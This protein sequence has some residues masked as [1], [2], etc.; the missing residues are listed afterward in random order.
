MPP[1]R[2]LP[3]FDYDDFDDEAEELHPEDTKPILVLCQTNHAL[4]SVLVDLIGSCP[5]DYESPGRPVHEDRVLRLGGSS[6]VESIK[7]RNAMRVLNQLSTERDLRAAKHRRRSLRNDVDRDTKQFDRNLLMQA[8]QGEIPNSFSEFISRRREEYHAIIRQLHGDIDKITDEIPNHPKISERH[9]ELQCSLHEH[10]QQLAE[11]QSA[12]QNPLDAWLEGV[13]LKGQAPQHEADAADEDVN[14]ARV[15]ADADDELPSLPSDDYGKL[16]PDE[17]WRHFDYWTRHARRNAKQSLYD[18]CNLYED[19][20]KVATRLENEAMSRLMR[21]ARVI[22]ATT[23]GC[24]KFSQVMEHLQ[25]EIIVVE[26]AAEVLESHIL[27]VLSP[28]T[29]HILLIGDHKQ[30]QPKVNVLEMERKGLC[31]SLMERLVLSGMKPSVLLTQRRMREEICAVTSPFYAPLQIESHASTRN[32]PQFIKGLQHPLWFVTHNCPESRDDGS[33][34]H[35]EYEA[36]YAIGL[37]GHLLR[38][39]YEAS[40][41]TILVAYKG[42]FHYL[43]E[44]IRNL[45][46]VWNNAD[47]RGAI[48]QG[49]RRIKVVCVDNFQGEENDI[50][51]LSLVRS[52][53]TTHGFLKRENRLIVALS[54]ARWG[55]YVLANMDHLKT[56][57]AEW[58]RVYSDAQ[59]RRIM[60]PELKIQCRRHNLTAPIK[61]YKDFVTVSEYGGCSRIC[62]VRMDC[63]HPCKRKCH[64]DNYDH[65]DRVCEE[66]CGRVREACIPP[67]YCEHPCMKRCEDDCGE[68]SVMVMKQLSCGHQQKAPCGRSC[69]QISCSQPCKKVLPCGHT[70]RNKC[71]SRCTAC[72]VPVPK[73]LPCGHTVDVPCHMPA[74]E[75]VCPKPCPEKLACDHV[76]GLTCGK[77]TKTDDGIPLHECWMECKRVLVCGHVCSSMCSKMCPPCRKPCMM[78]CDHSKCTKSCG[79]ECVRCAMPCTWSCEHHRC[80]KQCW[81]VCSRKKCDKPCPK[82]LKCGHPCRG[83]CGDPCPEFCAECGIGGELYSNIMLVEP[84]DNAQYIQL[85][86]EHIFDIPTFDHYVTAE[87]GKEK[88]QWLLCPTC[89]R[90][91]LPHETGRYRAEVNRSVI[92][93]NAVRERVRDQEKTFKHTRCNLQSKLSDLNILDERGGIALTYLKQRVQQARF[94]E[95]VPLQRQVELFEFRTRAQRWV[96]AY[97]D[98]GTELLNIC[99]NA[100]TKVLTEESV[101]SVALQVRSL[102]VRGRMFKIENSLGHD[103]MHIEGLAEFRADV[104]ELGQ[105][106]GVMTAETIDD[107]ER[108]VH[109][110]E[111]VLD[112]DRIIAD[113]KMA[114]SA[115]QLGAG[116]WFRCPNGHL[117]VIAD[118]GGAVTGSRCPDCDAPIGGEG[119]GLASGN[120]FAGGDIDATAEPSWNVPAMQR[121]I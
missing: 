63:G 120:E 48:L 43:T 24:A 83:V 37:A 103:G 110:H 112:R 101:K 58:Q 56:A 96:H 13:S 93:V 18:N 85:G 19:A 107:W 41:I 5:D 17:R 26:E 87:M 33:S 98:H 94:E 22:G 97:G 115:L 119:Y 59:G 27:S 62:N 105:L 70:C 39:G 90:P 46:N 106:T 20:C 49:L 15:G 14:V 73:M 6:R 109:E 79:E 60:G 82:K 25:P 71:G 102:S 40:Q 23:T 69:D 99:D 100:I 38:Q 55:M 44:K 7:K 104:T 57:S 31:V 91:I 89:R 68:C 113:L 75:M 29:K 11:T 21:T 12:L 86:C 84:E 36:L 34:P 78:R 47:K 114:A 117:Y 50:V 8:A 64:S 52:G 54:R 10:R 66:K 9:T 45:R 95:I 74:N 30:L 76:C 16:P 42:Q 1:A 61:T 108:R 111:K 81:E 92:S 3:G 35:N 32:H 4:D 121:G 51:I 28:R 65:E 2:P 88:V 72:S 116:H 118:C 80:A 67:R 53:G 77:C